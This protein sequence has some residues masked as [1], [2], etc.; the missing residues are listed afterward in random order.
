MK[1]LTKEGR[2]MTHEVSCQSLTSGSRVEF[3]GILCGICDEQSGI[4]RN[5]NQVGR[6]SSKSIISL[7]LQSPFIHPSVDWSIHQFTHL[8]VYPLTSYNSSSAE[9]RCIINVINL[10]KWFRTELWTYFR[11]ELLSSPST[12]PCVIL[13]LL[14]SVL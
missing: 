3:Q 10:Q 1:S 14:C 7:I 4:R 6:L 5:S 12:D 11:I 9:R 2:A 8:F 13:L